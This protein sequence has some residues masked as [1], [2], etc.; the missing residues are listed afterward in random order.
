MD[1]G[2]NDNIS[3][4]GG[5]KRSKLWCKNFKGVVGKYK[6]DIKKSWYLLIVFCVLDVFFMGLYV[7]IYLIFIKFL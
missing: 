2:S 4:N 3:N 7:V 5:W 6:V 1:I